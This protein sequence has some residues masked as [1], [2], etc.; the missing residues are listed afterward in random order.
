MACGG[1]FLDIDGPTRRYMESS[2]GCWACFGEI[3]AREYSDLQYQRVHR[4]RVDAYAMQYPG[5]LSPSHIRSVALHAISL[6]TIFEKGA[7]MEQ[8][9][10]IIRQAAKDKDRFKWLSPPSSKGALTVADV[11]LAADA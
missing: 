10:E 8:A 6:C 7:D 9:T 11:H 5:Q 2:P 3:L 1:R 4:L